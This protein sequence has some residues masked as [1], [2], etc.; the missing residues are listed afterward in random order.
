MIKRLLFVLGMLLLVPGS[1]AA[2][3]DVS[4]SSSDI[5]FSN[6]YPYVGEIIRIYAT[7]TNV[8]QSDA[9]GSVR[10]LVNENTVGSEQPFSVL[11]GKSSTVFVDWE[12]S[13]GY[14]TVSAEIFNVDPSDG[15]LGNN[16]ASVANFLVNKDTDGDGVPDT[17]DFD[18]DN[19][20]IND[21]V[22]TI[23][24][25]DPLK[26]D[27]DGDGVLDGADAFPL[28]PSEQ[29]DID[30]DGIGNNVDTDDDNDG[31]PDAQDP[32]PFDPSV[33]GSAPEPAESIS[34]PTSAAAEPIDTASEQP[35]SIVTQEP[36]L[37]EDA[38]KEFTLEEVEYTFPDQSDA[39]HAIDLVI[40]K[41]RKSW[42]TWTFD[43]LGADESFIYLWD[44]GDGK[45]SQTKSPTHSF[46][47][48]GDYTV[49]LTVSDSS[50]GLGEAQESV[51]IGFWHL[52]NVWLATIIALLVAIGV[53]TIGYLIINTIVSKK[54]KHKK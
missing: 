43:I 27:T 37:T 44:F 11:A 25:T 52:G 54:I 40:A 53:G 29:Y 24:G 12:P 48:T 1:A 4:I 31:I 2:A 35:T 14:Y 39:D 20:G 46:G 26:R 51:S 49:T 17:E 10:F 32:A 15:V 13:E 28:N 45:L 41:S 19:D 36:A 5:S 34:E 3:V 42:N 38:D 30:R 22:E 9:R 21:G 33:P 6:K 18:D 47:G 50:G 7:V 8:G 16:K 23:N